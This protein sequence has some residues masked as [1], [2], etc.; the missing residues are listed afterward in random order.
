MSDLS[1]RLYSVGYWKPPRM[2]RDWS[3]MFHCLIVHTGKN[4]FVISSLYLSS[5]SLGSFSLVL[6]LCTTVKRLTLISRYT[7]HGFE[8]RYSV[9][10]KLSLVQA[11]QAQLPQF[12]LTGQVLQYCI[13]AALC[14]TCSS[15][16]MS[17]WYL[18]PKIIKKITHIIL[19]MLYS[20]HLW[21]GKY[22]TFHDCLTVCLARITRVVQ[23]AELK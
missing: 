7:T 19:L 8:G 6:P 20:V 13:V 17:A 12:F 22:V 5:I 14:Q 15:L 23:T 18:G 4:F 10:L 3:S 16:L 11:R 21:A 9:L 1:S 2:G